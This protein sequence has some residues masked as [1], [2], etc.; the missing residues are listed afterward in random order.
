MNLKELKELIELIQRT[1]IAELELEKSGVRVRIK[2]ER[3]LIP[4][5]PASEEIPAVPATHAA[6]SPQPQ[7][8]AV[9]PA[10]TPAGWLTLTA[11]VVGTFY[12]SPAPDADPY[13][14]V[15]SVVKKGQILCVIEAMKLMNE[16]ESEWDGKVVEILVENAQPVEYGGPLFRIEPLTP[17]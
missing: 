9:T 7:A 1:E 4:P 10:V 8:Q 2:K 6:E 13:V 16:I 15:G 12:R 11:P 17:A 3:P 14:E 5:P